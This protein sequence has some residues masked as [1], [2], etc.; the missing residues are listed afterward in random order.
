MGYAVAA[1]LDHWLI[2]K[3]MPKSFLDEMIEPLNGYISARE[4]SELLD[5]S[6]SRSGTCR[7]ER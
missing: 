5:F 4:L 7:K 3:Q 6:P 1:L 2:I